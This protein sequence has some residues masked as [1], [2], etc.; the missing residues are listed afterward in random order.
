MYANGIDRPIYRSGV[1]D[2]VTPYQREAPPPLTRSSDFTICHPDMRRSDAI[3]I[4]DAEWSFGFLNPAACEVLA[5]SPEELHGRSIWE[6]FPELIGSLFEARARRVMQEGTPA[7]FE[8]YFETISSWL[9]VDI[10]P[11]EG[12]LLVTGHDVTERR[13]AASRTA[14]AEAHYRRVVENLP[15]AVYVLDIHGRFTEI[16][17]AGE[18]ILGRPAQELLGLPYVDVIP[19]ANHGPVQA[20]FDEVTRGEGGSRQ[21]DTTV[22]RPNGEERQV[23]ITVATI[24]EEGQVVGA[25]GIAR[26][27]TEQRAAQRAL[28]ESE[29][30]F[31]QIA[32]NVR[33]VF[34]IFTPDFSEVLYMSPVYEELWG[35]PVAELAKN[36]LSFLDGVHPEDVDRLRRAMEHIRKAMVSIEYRVVRPDGSIRWI[37]TRGFPVVGDDGEVYRVVGTGEDITN[38][39]L[40]DQQV[41]RAER[42]ASVATLVGGV[43]HE[44]NNPLH[45]ILNFAQLLALD[46]PDPERREDLATIQR[47]AER[48]G[49]IVADLKQIARSSLGESMDI[50]SF[51]LNELVR[52]VV[53]A[54]HVRPGAERVRLDLELDEDLEPIRGDRV[55]IE[56]LIT[57]LVANG[58]DAV[59]ADSGQRRA[60]VIVRTRA[61]P[62]GVIL[63]VEDTGV[64]IQANLL[65]RIFD[66][67]FTTK[68]PGEGTGLGLSLVH[69][70]VEDHSGEIRIESAVGIGTTV[71]VELPLSGPRS[72]DDS[73]APLL[74][75]TAAEPIRILVIDDE[76]SVRSVLS[77]HFGRAGHTVVEATDGDSAVRLLDTIRFDVVVSDVRMPGLSLEE[78]LE[79][80]DERGLG[81]RVILLTGDSSAL[82]ALPPGFDVPIFDKPVNLAALKDVVEIVGRRAPVGG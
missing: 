4:L 46:E 69:R 48:M 62:A 20:I 82:G 67:F 13:A 44:L 35:R 72:D 28:R 29:Q 53:R 7:S 31:R 66:P 24:R 55:Q 34:W 3:C 80:L 23:E 39:R 10:Y 58:I 30:N 49:R 36:P 16:N 41:R 8:A 9:L 33:E 75:S 1:A 65:Q 71:R 6:A 21:L 19:E 76:P 37:H 40:R 11:Y 50:S 77:R 15:D 61:V 45:A 2:A 22:V 27:V 18:R 12:G 14:A 63:E 73:P 79:R 68:P 64:G 42:L 57:S 5:R 59:E 60:V 32:E 25:H 70:A 17:P 81:E 38:R 43:A 74:A 78:L 51:D 54:Q 56:Q 52:L 47:E 26:D